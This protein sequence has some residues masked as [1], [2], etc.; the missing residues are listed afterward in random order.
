MSDSCATFGAWSASRV[1]APSEEAFVDDR[2][3]PSEE[4][5]RSR[6]VVFANR[7][8]DLGIESGGREFSEQLLFGQEALRLTGELGEHELFPRHRLG[9]RRQ[10]VAGKREN[11]ER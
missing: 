10:R 6:A 11:E 3:A 4:G 5:V 9:L 2:P 8:T 7:H 1:E